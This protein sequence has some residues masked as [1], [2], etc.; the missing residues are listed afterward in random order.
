[1]RHHFRAPPHPGGPVAIPLA[2]VV[3]VGDDDASV[4]GYGADELAYAVP[5]AEAMVGGAYA[6]TVAPGRGSSVFTGR[7]N[8]VELVSNG[9]PLLGPLL[10][11]R[12]NFARVAWS[13]LRAADVV[14]LAQTSRT[15]RRYLSSM[16]ALWKHLLI[17][18]TWLVQHDGAP[19]TA[20][21]PGLAIGDL[22]GPGRMLAPPVD[23][24]S[25]S[26]D[27]LLV[28][29]IVEGA[30]ALDSL[31]RVYA[32]ETP[33]GAILDDAGAESV[34]PL[35]AHTVGLYVWE[36]HRTERAVRARAVAQRL[37]SPIR[38]RILTPLPH[39]PLLEARLW[40]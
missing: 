36:S 29:G 13:G 20:T 14:A 4:D 32:L 6:M 30:C 10:V 23:W 38:S 9:H 15:L 27:G 12:S 40:R 1:M 16:H 5:V 22:I 8:T 18:E 19:D 39:Y 33:Y 21:H 28:S 25:P 7:L 17:V 35:F 3:V 2:E 31:E 37:W 26:V 24:E 11:A 34:S